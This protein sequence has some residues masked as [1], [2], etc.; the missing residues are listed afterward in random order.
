VRC[1]TEIASKPATP[2]AAT[3]AP[4]GVVAIEPAQRTVTGPVV[5]VRSASREDAEPP[6]AVVVDLEYVQRP[7]VAV[8][9]RGVDDDR[10]ERRRL[11]DRLDLRLRVDRGDRLLVEARMASRPSTRASSPYTITASSL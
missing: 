7:V 8:R 11:Q 9:D 3:N 2:A 1:Q 10:V 5:M 6:D 4:N